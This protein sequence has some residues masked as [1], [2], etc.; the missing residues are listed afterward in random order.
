MR[1]QTCSSRQRLQATKEFR[2]RIN[3]LPWG[4][5]HQFNI[6][7]QMISSENICIQVTLY[8][9][10]RLYLGIYIYTYIHT[11]FIHTH[12]H[13]YIATIKEKRGHEFEEQRWTWN[14]WETLEEEKGKKKWCNYIIISKKFKKEIAHLRNNYSWFDFA[15]F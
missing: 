6:S 1:P 11:H 5:A 13:M 10:S 8:R 7:Y 12:T 2:R 9:L 14:I 3:S 15:F 4:R